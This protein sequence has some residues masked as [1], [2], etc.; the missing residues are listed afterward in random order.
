MCKV[1]SLVLSQDSSTAVSCNSQKCQFFPVGSLSQQCE[2]ATRAQDSCASVTVE[3]VHVLLV[4]L[5][6]EG[7]QSQHSSDRAGL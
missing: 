6:S 1:S 3:L 2:G 5:L 7:K 4:A